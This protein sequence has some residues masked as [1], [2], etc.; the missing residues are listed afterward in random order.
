MIIIVPKM[1]CK[2]VPFHATG[3]K[4]NNN[5]LNPFYSMKKKKFIGLR[6]LSE[7]NLATG[8]YKFI[9]NQID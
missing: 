2:T 9:I 3:M 6:K 8:E 7:F 1:N 4:R 5:R